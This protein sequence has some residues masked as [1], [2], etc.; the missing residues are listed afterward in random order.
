MPDNESDLQGGTGS[1]YEHTAL[2]KEALEEPLDIPGSGPSDDEEQV[3]EDP[4]AD[5]TK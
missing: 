1:L 4:S 3:T 2:G 5:P